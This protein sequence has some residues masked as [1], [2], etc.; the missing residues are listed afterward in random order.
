MV[1]SKVQYPAFLGTFYNDNDI[2]RD[3]GFTIFYMGIIIG[4]FLATLLCPLI[5]VYLVGIMPLLRLA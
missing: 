2:R 1:F 4:S 3:S 5:V